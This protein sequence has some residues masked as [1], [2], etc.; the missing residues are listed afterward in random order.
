M[1]I[2]IAP[3]V[4]AVDIARRARR[5]VVQNFAFAALYNLAAIPLAAF[6][7]VTPLIAAGAMAGSSLIVTLNALRLARVP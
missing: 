3:I 1:A 5:L 7:L 2:P 4:E 6:G